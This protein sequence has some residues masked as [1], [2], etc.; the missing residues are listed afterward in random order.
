MYFKEGVLRAARNH[1]RIK[2]AT[3]NRHYRKSKSMEKKRQGGHQVGDRS[4]QVCVAFILMALSRAIFAPALMAAENHEVTVERNVAAKM[5]DGVTLR[6][7]IYRPK[8]VGTF[9]VL[10]VRTPYDKTGTINFGLKAA[11]RGYG[12]IAQ[13]VRGRFE[14]EEEWHTVEHESQDG[15]DTVE[16]AAALP[17]SNGKGG[18]FGGSY[19]GAT[20]FL[21]A[22]AKPPTRAGIVP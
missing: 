21:A 4:V 9:P 1:R 11:A 5:R 12:V 17:Y 20:Q 15:Y 22:L 14:S 13:D 2:A 18:I 10:L 7:D 8:E 3:Q 19:V 16:W 6:A